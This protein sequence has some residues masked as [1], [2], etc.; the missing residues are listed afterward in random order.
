MQT[1][2]YY[3]VREFHGVETSIF[4]LSLSPFFFT[5]LPVL[6]TCLFH[7]PPSTP[8]FALFLRFVLMAKIARETRGAYYLTGRLKK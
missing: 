2:R 7:S 6:F 1:S 3:G 4:S 5:L 8:P